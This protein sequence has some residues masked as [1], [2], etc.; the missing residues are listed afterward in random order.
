METEHFRIGID[1]GGTKTEAVLLDSSGDV[2]FRHRQ[3]TRR[4]EGYN[5]ILNGIRFRTGA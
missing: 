3:P 4:S 2:V 1:L 5:G